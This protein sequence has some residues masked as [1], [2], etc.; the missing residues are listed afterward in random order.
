MEHAAG[1]AVV[2]VLDHGDVDVQRVTVLERLVV[3][4]AV[5]DHMV[6]RGADRLRVALV[7]ERCRDGL[8]DVDD[9]VVAQ[10]VQLFGGDT[11]LDVFLD[12]FQHVG[13]Q[14]ASDAHLLDVFCGLDGD[15]HYRLS[16][17]PC[18][19]RTNGKGR[20]LAEQGA[21]RSGYGWRIG[22]AA[23]SIAGK[24][25]PTGIVLRLW[26]LACRRWGAQRPQLL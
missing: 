9:I 17:A 21:D 23:Q 4:D 19:A 14:A 8:L 18:T 10:A 12:H 26:E 1:V 20:I 5:A 7:V 2:A 3:G 22:T 15:G 11:G 24:P 16:T 6:D 13:G 25:A